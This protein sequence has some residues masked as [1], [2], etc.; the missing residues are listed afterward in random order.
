MSNIINMNDWAKKKLAELG[1][2]KA[3]A[4]TAL[5][6]YVVETVIKQKKEKSND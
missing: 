5:E 1:Q 2:S 4:Y 6:P 3:D